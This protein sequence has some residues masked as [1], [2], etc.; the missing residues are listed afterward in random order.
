MENNILSTLEKNEQCLLE[1][2]SFSKGSIIYREGEI[3]TSIAIVVSGAVKIYSTNYSGN[4]IVFNVLEKGE[5]FGNNLVFSDNPKFKGDVF[6][7]KDCMIVLIS[8]ENLKTILQSNN[9]FF[10]QYLRIQSNLVKKL[11][12]TIR[13]LSL[14]SAEERFLFYLHENK[15]EINY[16]SI[17][18]LANLLH[19][20][21]ETLSRTL[22][23][24][25]KK[26]AVKRSSHKIFK[27][28]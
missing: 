16:H 17:T 3:C 1:V 28:N 22:T 5:M 10:I 7:L 23:L 8:K 2:K 24:L 9:A 13:M 27:V 25:E 11:N 12:S 21:R 14:S 19:L 20:K 4:E 18:E 26:N 15:G 6:V